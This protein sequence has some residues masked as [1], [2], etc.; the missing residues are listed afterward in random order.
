MAVALAHA[1][2]AWAG[3]G[4]DAATAAEIACTLEIDRLRLP[5]GKQDQYA[6]AFG[7]LNSIAFSP[8]GVTV[9]PLPLSTEAREGLVRRLLLFA[10]GATRESAT[11]L[12]QQ[13]AD[14][15]HN[16]GVIASLHHIKALAGEMRAALEREN[17]DEFGQ[18]LHIAWQQKKQLSRDISND[19]IDGWYEAARQAGALG[20]KIT[21]AGG[22]GF[23]LFYCPPSRQRALRAEMQAC[24]LREL[25]FGFDLA[26]ACVVR[27]CEAAVG[28]GRPAA[29]AA[30]AQPPRTSAQQIPRP[31]A[32]G[33]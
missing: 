13:R 19:A 29:H 11:I 12:R 32:G 4:T 31:S 27:S 33:G 24:G 22:G 28:L 30:P 7:G 18:L 5:I 25:P 14:T 15:R 8:S 1:L 26:G 16:P 2:A 17:L 10:T 6:S 21:G 9:T 3:Q 20:G 23:L